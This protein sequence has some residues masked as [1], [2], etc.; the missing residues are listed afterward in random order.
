KKA[1]ELAPEAAQYREYLG[2][3]YHTLK[4]SD[5][6][7]ATWRPI[8][9]GAN[10]TAKNLGRLAEVFGGFGYLKEATETM[11]EAGKL[12]P[13]NFNLQGKYSELL[14]QAERF[15]DALKQLE[16]AQ[17]LAS[18]DEEAEAVLQQQIK[19]LQG[20]ETLE[21]ETVALQKELDTGKDATAKRWH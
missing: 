17:K 7:L 18:N 5:E 16:N 9:A 1:I 15:P 6:A 21:A 13:D 3:Y 4:R 12:E 8:A 19:C 20:G 11:A 2:E 10:R 14:Y